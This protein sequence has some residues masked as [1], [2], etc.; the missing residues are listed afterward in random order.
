MAHDLQQVV[1]LRIPR[2]SEP[3]TQ[4][5]HFAIFLDFWEI[6]ESSMDSGKF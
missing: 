1:R 3:I 6:P 5:W 2:N 4:G